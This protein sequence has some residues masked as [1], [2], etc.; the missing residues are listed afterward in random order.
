MY[1]TWLLSSENSL[2]FDY[3]SSNNCV[4]ISSDEINS[5]IAFF[6]TNESGLNNNSN[7]IQLNC[8]NII[9]ISKCIHIGLLYS[10]IL[11]CMH[12]SLTKLQMNAYG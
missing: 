2:V 7:I 4:Y 12:L 5:V 1:I 8:P 6:I 9:I 10:V 11:V 3:M